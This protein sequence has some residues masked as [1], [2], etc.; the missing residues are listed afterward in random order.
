MSARKGKLTKSGN[1]DRR[2]GPRRNDTRW[3]DNPRPFTLHDEAVN[4]AHVED[5][6]AAGMKCEKRFGFHG[7]PEAWLIYLATGEGAERDRCCVYRGLDRLVVEHRMAGET[8]FNGMGLPTTYATADE[9]WNMVRMHAS[10][11][12]A[13]YSVDASFDLASV[14]ASLPAWLTAETEG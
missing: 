6:E 10:V 2:Y 8:A 14:A 9:A 5:L 12:E 3:Q 11:R 4:L 13:S 7:R 1:V